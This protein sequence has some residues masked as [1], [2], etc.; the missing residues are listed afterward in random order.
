MALTFRTLKVAL[1]DFTDE[2]LDMDVSIHQGSTDEFF[3]LEGILICPEND[4]LDKG[5]PYLEMKEF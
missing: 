5:H 1:N 4:V 3:E 2:E